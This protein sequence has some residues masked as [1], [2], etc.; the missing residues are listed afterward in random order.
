[1]KEF[2]LSWDSKTGILTRNESNTTKITLTD[3]LKWDE[4]DE[5]V[6]FPGGKMPK[7]TVDT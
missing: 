1:M 6:V 7:F 5:K 3:S 4:K 2:G